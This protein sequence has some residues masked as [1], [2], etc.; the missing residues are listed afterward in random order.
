MRSIV[1]PWRRLPPELL[2]HIF[3]LCAE[4]DSDCIRKVDRMPL[5]VLQVCHAWRSLALA[6]PALWARL[7]QEIWEPDDITIT[8]T[9]LS[10]S[11]ACPLEL[12]VLVAHQTAE[13]EQLLKKHLH[14]LRSVKIDAPPTLL[15]FLLD[16]APLLQE[17]N[18]F[19]WH[20]WPTISDPAS[21]P[22]CTLRSLPSLHRFHGQHPY[23]HNIDIPWHQLTHLYMRCG[24]G[25]HATAH[26]NLH[27]LSRCPAL[28]L[29]ELSIEPDGERLPHSPSQNP[30]VLAHLKSLQV[31][32][33][34]TRSSP[35]PVNRLFSSLTL[36]ALHDLRILSWSAI[37]SPTIIG[38][39]LKRSASPLETL[40]LRGRP[41]TMSGTDVMQWLLP[42]TAT[43]T[44]L[45][46]DIPLSS[47]ADDLLH[48]L[49]YNKD[50]GCM[51]PNL[52]RISFP[53]WSWTAGLMADMVESRW[54][55]ASSL[56]Q[57]VG[58]GMD[59]QSCLDD[60]PRLQRLKNLGL[61]VKASPHVV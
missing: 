45:T 2:S 34:K 15:P 25:G 16:G 19:F 31:K 30:L 42:P 35:R 47:P 53:H 40:H 26:A 10:R 33:V 59:H 58:I 12:D 36:P 1:S 28:L 6:T 3:V 44:S 55:D 43:L 46:L 38:E 23:L 27:I 37:P 50:K 17:L 60:V 61:K 14:H 9:W 18:L 5:L 4:D 52:R 20:S 39:F 11:G 8:D 21:S 13:T 22:R 51:C 41:N 49:T 57:E 54:R 29:C 48:A 32:V 56:L 7:T 24:S